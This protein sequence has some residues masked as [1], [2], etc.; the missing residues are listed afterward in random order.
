MLR[1]DLLI[2]VVKNVFIDRPPKRPKEYNFANKPPIVHGQLGHPVAIDKLLG[3]S[4]Y[5]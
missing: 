4:I 3:M 2:D 1:E 5:T